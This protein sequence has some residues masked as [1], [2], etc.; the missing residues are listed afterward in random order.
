MNDESIGR[1]EVQL[2]RLLFG[3]VV[4]AATLLVAG[5]ALW[6]TT[7]TPAAGALLNAGLIV[8]MATPIMRVAVSLIEYV[9]MRDWFFALTTLAV[10][11]VLFVSVGLALGR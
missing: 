11:T 5:L 2:G 4:C 10:L 9:R 7:T 8:L 6:V 3:G 1:L